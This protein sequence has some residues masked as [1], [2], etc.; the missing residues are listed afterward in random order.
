MPIIQGYEDA[1]D[2]TVRERLKTSAHVNLIYYLIVGA[3]AFCG[4]ILLIMFH[5]N[6]FVSLSLSQK[7]LFSDIFSNLVI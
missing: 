4:V 6:W 7:F 1:G 5:K 2:F 3:I